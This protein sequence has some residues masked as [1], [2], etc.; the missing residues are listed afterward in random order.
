[1]SN[2]LTAHSPTESQPNLTPTQ[3]LL[4]T[5]QNNISS[6]DA[7]TAIKAKE[8]AVGKPLSDISN[9]FNDS[10]INVSI[11]ILKIIEKN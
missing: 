8:S 2:S 10:Q 4:L 5:P 7:D 6:S 9:T 1:M 11:S 3:S